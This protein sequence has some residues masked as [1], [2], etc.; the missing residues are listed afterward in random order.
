MIK[1]GKM[2]DKKD[3]EPRLT[4]VQS[5]NLCSYCKDGANVKYTPDGMVIEYC[6]GCGG[7]FAFHKFNGKRMTEVK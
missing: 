7:Y 1:E 3:T 6:K 4:I 2:G 5:R